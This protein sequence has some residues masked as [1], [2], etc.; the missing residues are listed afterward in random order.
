MFES[1]LHNANCMM[2]CTVPNFFCRTLT[3]SLDTNLDVYL[4]GNAGLELGTIA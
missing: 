1:E 3:K 4:D 2:N